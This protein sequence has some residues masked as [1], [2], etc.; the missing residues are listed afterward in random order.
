LKSNDKNDNKNKNMINSKKK[1]IEINDDKF[2]ELIKSKGII[3]NKASIAFLEPVSTT[4]DAIIKEI[5]NEKVLCKRF[6]D[7]SKIKAIEIG[8][9]I[10][11]H[12]PK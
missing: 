12:T 11:S 5:I 10:I 8:K 2:I 4:P 6:F 7:L 3:K 1:N 9:Q